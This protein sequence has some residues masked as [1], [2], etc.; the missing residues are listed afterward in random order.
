MRDGTV[1]GNR[2]E[3]RDDPHGFN[4][5]QVYDRKTRA[6]VGEFRRLGDA[7][8]RAEELEER[9]A[10]RPRRTS[11]RAAIVYASAFTLSACTVL[12]RL[13]P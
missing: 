10:P 6:V 13:L 4:Q 3:V 9:H 8:T 2:F 5:H 1:K 12:R 7:N 11:L